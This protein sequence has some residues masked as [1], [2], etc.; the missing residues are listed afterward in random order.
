MP[1]QGCSC[2]ETYAFGTDQM[3][4][5]RRCGKSWRM[6][7]PSPEPAAKTELTAEELADMRS[8]LCSRLGCCNRYVRLLDEHT[9]LTASLARTNDALGDLLRT[10]D[11]RIAELES[12]LTIATEAVAAEAEAKVEGQRRA[13]AERTVLD[14]VRQNCLHG[15]DGHWMQSMLPTLWKADKELQGEEK[16]AELARREAAKAKGEKR[17]ECCRQ[18]LNPERTSGTICLAC[19]VL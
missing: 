5:C 3:V 18:P 9:A 14:I 15:G 10:S 19:E 7:S 2:D 6:D 1:D 12:A 8:N 17:C 4:H 16:A 13:T 11:A